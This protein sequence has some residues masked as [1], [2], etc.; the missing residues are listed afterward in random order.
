MTKTYKIEGL[1]CP[2][3]ASKVEAGIKK[4]KGVEDASVS[5]LAEKLIITAPEDMMDAIIK[6]A[7]KVARKVEPDCEISER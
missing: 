2:V 7:L 6:E 4:I 5:F 3:C 1:D